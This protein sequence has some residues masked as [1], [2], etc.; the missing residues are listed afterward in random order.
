MKFEPE[1]IA[2]KYNPPKLCL[3]YSDGKESYFHEF[4]I[5][6][7]DLNL[8]SEKIFQKLDLT[9][10]G[11]LNQ[12]DKGQILKLIKM[13][14]D[15]CAGKSFSSANRLRSMVQGARRF[16]DINKEI[17]DMDLYSSG[18]NSDQEIDFAELDRQMMS[19]GSE[20]IELQL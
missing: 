18:Q 2:V 4:P 9:H 5:Q 15:N 3:I 19:S 10:P 1:Q 8:S 13:V 11:Y 14:K 7:E 17:G 20:D 6:N 12:L 16:E